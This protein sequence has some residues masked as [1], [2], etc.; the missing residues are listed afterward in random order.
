MMY[1]TLEKHNSMK[2]SH[3]LL[4]IDHNFNIPMPATVDTEI[5]ELDS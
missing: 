4:Q 1:S 5:T 2:L 3:L